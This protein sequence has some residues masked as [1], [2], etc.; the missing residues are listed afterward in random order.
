MIAPLL[1]SSDRTKNPST[2]LIVSV[3][4]PNMTNAFDIC[5]L[6]ILPEQRLSFRQAQS[7][8]TALA[9]RRSPEWA[10]LVLAGSGSLPAHSAKGLDHRDCLALGRTVA[11][12]LI[13]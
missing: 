7:I 2:A 6:E 1:S 10:R 8:G 11:N 3:H 9:C 12:T 4:W 5:S 13:T